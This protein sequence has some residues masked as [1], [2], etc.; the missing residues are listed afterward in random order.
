MGSWN[1]GQVT[2]ST[3]PAIL[4]VVHHHHHH[5]HHHQN[6]NPSDSIR[7][8]VACFLLPFL[9]LFGFKIRCTLLRK[10][11][12][13]LSHKRRHIAEGNILHSFVNMILVCIGI[14]EDLR[15]SERTDYTA[16]HPRRWQH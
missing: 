10:I 7:V 3:N 2:K 8:L 14:A 6:Q 11:G 13:I 16:L 1:F 9:L 15:F 4:G 5:H 12:N